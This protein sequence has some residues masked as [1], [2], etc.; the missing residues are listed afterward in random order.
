MKLEMKS[1]EPNVTLRLISGLTTGEKKGEH[2]Q[3]LI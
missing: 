2:V 3:G 1:S